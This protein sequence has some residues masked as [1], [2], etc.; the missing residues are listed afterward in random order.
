MIINP[1]DAVGAYEVL[2]RLGSGGAGRVFK[3]RHSVTGRIEAIKVLLENHSLDDA[4]ARRFL[5]EVQLQAQMSHPNIVQVFNAF[6][7]EQN[8]VMAMEYVQG[9]PLD[10][11][12][13]RDGPTLEQALDYCC[14]TLSALAY[15][16]SRGVIHR[17]VKPANL[18]LTPEGVVRV[19]DF[20]LAK[21][22]ESAHLTKTGTAIGSFHYAS[23]EQIRCRDDL[24]ERADIYSVG[25]VLYEL[26]TGQKPF[27]TS[28]VF[29]LMQAHV[30]L[31]PQQPFELDRSIPV[32]LD[33][34]ILRSLEKNPGDR[35]TSAE[36]FR[37]E[38]KAVWD[39]L[40]E[41]TR[42]HACGGKRDTAGEKPVADSPTRSPTSRKGLNV[43]QRVAGLIM[44][45]L[46]VLPLIAFLRSRS[47]N[48]PPA[49]EPVSKLAVELA[50]STAVH[51]V[52][53]PAVEEPVQAPQLPLP[54]PDT[55]DVRTS[56]KPVSARVPVD[57]P[58]PKT[59]PP[60]TDS[61][62]ETEETEKPP[63]PTIQPLVSNQPEASDTLLAATPSEPTAVNIPESLR[64]RLTRPISSDRPDQTVLAAVVEPAEL[65]GATVEGVV[66]DSK[67]SGRPRSQSNLELRINDLSYDRQ[68]LALACR[69]AGVRNSKGEADRDDG[70]NALKTKESWVSRGKE[71]AQKVGSAVVGF[72]G[73]NRNKSKR[74]STTKL[75]AKAPRI[76][77][78]AGS[79]FDLHVFPEGGE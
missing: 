74:I 38:L 58:K 21:T 41:A 56:T 71:S 40:D 59:S 14:Q 43:T 73:I 7:I 32:S 16:H 17:D 29:D 19:A 8:L 1:G 65:A 24:D 48:S 30:A 68:V 75:T 52:D 72:F 2:S 45:V 53:P 62:V 4:Q 34:V 27:R 64:V 5:R 51:L 3:A 26:V 57:S 31:Q 70:G 22:S 10:Q 69:I 47:A 67:S 60:E 6:W 78:A 66:V 61:I 42:Q 13:C 25:T 36:E 11:R 18:L 35:F 23:P 63:A 9:N 12:L 49:Q 37:A 44:V 77:L 76:T 15:A 46:A 28:T 20:G 39:N 50:P 79:E 55:R 54:E 33:R